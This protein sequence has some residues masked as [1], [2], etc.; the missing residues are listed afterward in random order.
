MTTGF[1]FC[2]ICGTPR[3][4]AEQ[5]FCPACGSAFAAE[6]AVL[7]GAL[8][9]GP[10]PPGAPPAWSTPPAGEPTAQAP[11]TAPPAVSDG[12]APPA[13]PS[14]PA[15][16]G[17]VPSGVNRPAIGVVALEQVWAK[18]NAHERLAVTGAVLI[19][20]SWLLGIVL[21]NGLFGAVGAGALGLVGAIAVVVAVYLRNSPTSNVTWPAPYA[22]ILLGISAVVGVIALLQFL[23][24]V[25][26]LADLA[27]YGGITIVV[28]LALDW[29]G[30]ALMLWGSY[31][32]WQ[33]NKAPAA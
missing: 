31:Q 29:I 12:A 22:T 32:E 9:A 24:L 23:Q 33:S 10:V 6:P 1:G 4:A 13:A 11:W 15:A 16:T 3:T 8:V 14:A 7:P 17:V 20:V 21:S 18:A 19:L 5:K 25:G 28:V 26:I 30:A 2:P 27:I